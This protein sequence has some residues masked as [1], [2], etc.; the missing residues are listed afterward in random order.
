MP[1]MHAMCFGHVHDR[2]RKKVL[3]ILFIV[4]ND[5]KQIKIWTNPFGARRGEDARNLLTS[6]S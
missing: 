2:V 6:S 1:V 3:S 4:H 5:G